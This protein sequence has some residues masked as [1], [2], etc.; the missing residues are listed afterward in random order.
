MADASLPRE[1]SSK[2][3]AATRLSANLKNPL[4][5]VELQSVGTGSKTT[6]GSRRTHN[7]GG[8]LK[9]KESAAG[10]A[11]SLKSRRLSSM[12]RMASRQW[13]NTGDPDEQGGAPL[14]PAASCGARRTCDGASQ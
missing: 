11:Q 13:R 10:F 7:A 6:P 2:D 12:N 5:G 9:S 3:N 1:A 4:N 8:R 14:A